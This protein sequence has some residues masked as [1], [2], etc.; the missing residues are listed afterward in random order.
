[1]RFDLA[2]YLAVPVL[3]IVLV[4]LPYWLWR[5]SKTVPKPPKPIRRRH[6]PGPFAGLMHKPQ[7]RF[8]EPGKSLAPVSPEAISEPME[9]GVRTDDHGVSYPELR[10]YWLFINVLTFSRSDSTAKGLAKKETFPL[11]IAGRHSLCA[12]LLMSIKGRVGC[13]RDHCS[14]NAYPS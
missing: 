8:C 12:T 10:A 5:R 14:Y 13:N 9:W 11:A 4:L 1:M 6:E 7:W 2:V 3:L